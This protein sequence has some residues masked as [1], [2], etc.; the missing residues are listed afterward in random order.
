[1]AAHSPFCLEG[2]EDF[3][4]GTASRWSK[5]TALQ[6]YGSLLNAVPKDLATGEVITKL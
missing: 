3:K 1:M 5:Q 4:G 2:I 6:V